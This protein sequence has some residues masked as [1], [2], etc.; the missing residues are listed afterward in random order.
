MNHQNDVHE[1]E[2]YVPFEPAAPSRTP[3]KRSPVPLHQGFG[4]DAEA[5]C[6]H[7][8]T[9][10][11][12]N[13]HEKEN[14]IHQLLS[15]P[16]SKSFSKEQWPKK[17]EEDIL[18]EHEELMKE[19]KKVSYKKENVKEKKKESHSLPYLGRM[20]ALSA[21][22]LDLFV[23]ASL[24]IASILVHYLFKEKMTFGME[25]QSFFISSIPS[26]DPLLLLN[27]FRV[28]VMGFLFIFLV[29]GL[30][31][32]LWGVSLGQYAAGV[33]SGHSSSRFKNMFTVWVSCLLSGGGVLNPLWFLVMPSYVPFYPLKRLYFE[34]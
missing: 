12:K 15:Q 23:S 6:Q 21:S 1:N 2:R 11:R 16:A 8:L 4:F 14:K 32:F 7:S 20:R 34:E 9:M 28:C 25:F 27:L 3:L 31:G 30:S 5:L 33:V 19:E 17:I 29:Q 24:L 22:V 13:A 10:A 18:L 26:L